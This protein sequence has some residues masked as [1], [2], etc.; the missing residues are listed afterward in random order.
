[1]TPEYLTKTYGI[2]IDISDL[3]KLA[4][5]ANTRSARRA[6]AA[7]TFPFPVYKLGKRLVG[8]APEVA[9]VLESMERL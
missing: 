2:T 8:K 3:A 4:H 1:M 5:Y 7:G 6:V 9:E